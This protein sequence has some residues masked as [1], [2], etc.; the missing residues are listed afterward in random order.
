MVGL[1]GGH[2]LLAVYKSPDGGILHQMMTTRFLDNG[3]HYPVMFIIIRGSSRKTHYTVDLT[4]SES[5]PDL[6]G[7]DQV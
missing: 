5:K 2:A 6:D 4:E 3:C 7:G 1:R